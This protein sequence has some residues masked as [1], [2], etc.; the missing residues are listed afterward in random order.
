MY[1]KLTN[2]LGQYDF[3]GK[4]GERF[5]DG[6]LGVQVNGNFEQRDRSSEQYNL[7][8][9]GSRRNYTDYQI[10]DFTLGYVDEARKRGGVGLLLDINTPD[11][12]SIR[13]NNLFNQTD[14]DYITYNRDY[15]NGGD[16]VYYSAWDR[17]Q[18]INSF[19]SSIRGDNYLLDMNINWGVSFAQSRSSYPYNYRMQFSEPPILDSAGM[20]A[21]PEGVWKGPV[22][23]FIQYAYNNFRASSLDTAVYSTEKN[24]DKE[25]TAFLDISRKYN[26]GDMMSGEIKA[27]GKYRYRNRFK[28]SSSLMAPY[29]LG[30]Y[31]TSYLADDG[32]VQAKNFAGT[33]FANLAM[34]GKLVLLTNFLDPTPATRNIFDKYSLNPLIN[35]DAL[36]EWYELNK[37][38]IGTASGPHEYNNDPETAG[39]YYDIVERVTAGYLM[40]TFNIGSS[41][42]FIAGVRV[43]SENN[44]YFSKYNSSALSGFPTTGTFVDTSASFTETIWLPNFHLTVRPLDFLNVRMAA[45]RA[46]ARPDFNMRLNKLVARI[47]NP[48]NIVTS[49]NPGLR[50]AKAWNFEINTSL[51]GNEIGL[52]T[53]SAFYR[54]IDDMFHLIS[55]IPCDY[56]RGVGSVLDTLG[57]TWKM[58]FPMNS[59]M[60]L[61]YP[62]NSAQPTKV[63][64]FELEHQANLGFL[65]GLLSNI[66]L[67]YNFSLV[68]SETYVLS[69]RVDTTWI[70]IP[71]I[72]RVPK[73]SN[74][75]IDEKQKLE[76]Q[77]EFYGNV[78]LGYDIGGFS[79]RLSVF[80]QGEYNRSYSASRRSDP[81]VQ[82][83]SRWDLSLRQRMTENFS[84]FFNL[85]NFSSVEEQVYT[86]NRVANWE[87][88]T[89]NQL[90]GLSGDLGV[91]VEF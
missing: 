85:N 44:D 33:R 72:G 54:R 66:V 76:G 19:N 48:R 30:Y 26:L 59:P 37:S 69:Y 35:R 77:P 57:V 50:N 36:R 63:W 52:F 74:I 83:F 32:T 11:S 22:E 31:Q 10:T 15:P 51:F 67:S 82:N 79:G 40:N 13:I 4:Y 21:I 75:I 14:R 16:R 38:G 49:G 27:G 58:P 42:T 87:T 17:E 55:N 47:T 25:R 34:V 86:T 68:R 73:Y 2:N 7:S 70:V 84:V 61:T 46:L 65:P 71:L 18:K 1:S 23:S 3:T 91:R 62:V 81:V 8:L 89:S 80:F 41:V 12:G 9:D 28:E 60:S 43:E 56:T 5:F 90:Y 39:D 88:L 29:Y 78:A 24:L 53:V 45:Y 6:V 20:R 64:G